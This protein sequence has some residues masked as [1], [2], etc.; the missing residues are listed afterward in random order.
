[1]FKNGVNI[2]YEGGRTAEEMMGYLKKK[3]G[4]SAIPVDDVEAAKKAIED[5]EV[6]AF[7]IFDS[8]DSKDAK[9]FKAAA[10]T[11]EGM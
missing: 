1:M 10:D 5:N 7:G 11:S 4:P 3:A 9:G 2:E 8:L 6:A